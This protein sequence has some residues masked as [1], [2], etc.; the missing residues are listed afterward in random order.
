MSIL[1]QPIY[2]ICR[3]HPPKTIFSL[4]WKASNNK[5]TNDEHIYL[6]VSYSVY[7]S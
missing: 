2:P 1:S 6:D 5:Q 4:S 3:Y 7:Y